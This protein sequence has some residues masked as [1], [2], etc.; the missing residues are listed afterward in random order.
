MTDRTRV[1]LTVTLSAVAIF[2]AAALATVHAG[3]WPFDRTGSLRAVENST[4][5]FGSVLAFAATFLFGSVLAWV[6]PILL[7]F[8]AISVARDAET[9]LRRLAL[10]G[11]LAAVIANA[12]FAVS[13]LTREVVPLRGQLGDWTA[14][15]LVAVFGEVGSAIVLVAGLLLI[16][17]GELHRARWVARVATAAASKASD[18]AASVREAIAR[19]HEAA[20]DY[21]KTAVAKSTATAAEETSQD[22]EVL[23]PAASTEPW[24][25]PAPKRRAEPE[26]AISRPR[27]AEAKPREKRAAK[28][29][30]SERTTPLEDASLPP[31]SILVHPQEDGAGYTRDELKSWSGVLE[32]KLTQF[33]VD[34]KVTAVHHGPVVTTFEFEPAPGVRI[35]DIVSRSDDL[36]LAM[37]ARSLRMI[38]PIPGRAAVGI[39]MPNP[40]PRTVYLAEVLSEVTEKQRT[41][42]IAIGLGVDVV[43]QPFLMNLCDAPH[44]LIAGTTGSGKSVCLNTILTSVLLHYRPSDVQLLLVDPKMVEMSQYNGIPH[45]MHPVIT[46]PKDAARVLEY[47]VGEMSRRNELFRREG[48]RNI[49]SYNAKLALEKAEKRIDDPARER[50]AYIVLVVDE[51]GDLALAKGVDIESLLTRLAQMARAAGIHMVLATQRPSVDVIVGKT[52]ANFP[53]RIA[54]RVATKVDSRTVIDAIGADKLLGKGDMLYMDA[55]HPLPVRAHGAW[56]SEA[57]IEQIIAHWKA[58]RYEEST[59]ELA[60][61]RAGA[62]SV[63][64]D[65]DPLF[66]E[67]KGVVT[68]YKQGS[69]SL[70]QRKLHVGYS[71]AARLLDQLEQQGVVGPPDGSKPREVYLDA[72]SPE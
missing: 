7:V 46:D 33:G 67:A 53:T 65:L 45:L 61:S 25:E 13:P 17:L 28:R 23:A 59:L 16:V 9:P 62:A 6:I 57:E 4:G 30:T 24:A 35:K 10:K 58:Y 44:L 72:R 5:P 71:R 27:A 26:I 20:T 29:D 41:R 15:G 55:H 54:F 39:E 2:I 11:L 12:F 34:G 19:R 42:G 70:L 49:D 68:R 60:E 50:L 36:A 38:A 37:R 63:G 18:A 40:R 32:E 47:L 43:G 51:L 8:L 52:K 14:S 21:V 22:E 66:D 1:F 31:M 64:D 56:V 48:V 69:T 3:D